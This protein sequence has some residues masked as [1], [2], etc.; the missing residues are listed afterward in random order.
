[1]DQIGRNQVTRTSEAIRS[2]IAKVT[3]EPCSCVRC[4]TCS[5][6]G[7]TCTVCRGSLVHYD[8]E[9]CEDCTNGIK[10]VCD[11]CTLLADL[12]YELEEK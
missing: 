10:Q 12:D 3:K 5:G 1:M 6:L 4:D 11:R 7:R 2:D 8:W 9:S